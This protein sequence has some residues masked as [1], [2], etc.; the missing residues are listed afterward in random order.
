MTTHY[1]FFTGIHMLRHLDSLNYISLITDSNLISD[2][3]ENEDIDLLREQFPII[4]EKV[5]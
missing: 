5:F 4:Y 2:G 1:N 3:G